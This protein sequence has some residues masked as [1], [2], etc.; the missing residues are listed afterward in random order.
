MGVARV[1]AL[2]WLAPA[3]LFNVDWT[4]HG[5]WQANTAAVVMILA[6]A[7][8]IE[9]ARHVRDWV[10][11][12][13]FIVAA[14]LL[15]YGNTK[16]AMRNL[17][18]ASEAVSEAKAATLAEGSH[19]GSQ[20]VAWVAR[21]AEQAKIAGEAPVGTLEA[22]L[23]A[24]QLSD[25]RV[26]NATKGCEDVTATASGKFCARVA[27]AKAKIEAAKERDKLDEKIAAL[28]APKTIAA[29]GAEAP[30]TDAYVANV[31]A[32][33][34]EAG[35]APSE[36]IVKAEESLTR[37]FLFELVAALGPSAWLVF[38]NMGA[39]VGST[40]AARMRKPVAKPDKVPAVAP[41]LPDAAD[42]LDRA[43]ADLFEV[44]PAGVM[45]SGEIRPLV[46][47]WCEA[48]GLKFDKKLEAK[49]WPKMG[50]RFTRDPNGGRPRYLGL[51]PRVKGPPRLAV[52]SNA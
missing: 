11:T 49:L 46:K 29:P 28:P 17:S 37:A 45:T 31:V 32:L 47:G 4:G 19:R 25:L 8:F 27:E 48:R 18:L 7:L 12:P 14:L 1:A 5:T 41:G 30:V 43:I 51:K 52:V 24:L 34:R 39:A 10:L 35:F 6:S 42:E 21:R 36:R 3:L 44:E 38:V 9:G 2:A 22:Q 15:V 20:G 50:Q 23:Q 33:L 26:W 16:Q 13:L 40:V